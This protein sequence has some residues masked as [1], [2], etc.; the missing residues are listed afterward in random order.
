MKKVAIISMYSGL[1]DRGVETWV[2]EVSSRL[3]ELQ[4]EVLVI[5]GANLK[6]DFNKKNKAYWNLI[7]IKFSI[8]IIKKLIS[9]KPD[10]VMP[11]NGGFESL[12]IKLLSFIFKW[13]LII[14]GH[15]GIGRD[16][17]WNI[18]IRP[19]CFVS[20]SMRGEKWAKSL[21]YSKGI[22]V[23]HIPHGVDLEK[24]NPKAK[25]VKLNLARPIYLCVSSDDD[26]KRVELAK[27][28]VEKIKGSFLHIGGDFKVAPANMPSYYTACDVFTLP[29]DSY[30]AFGI[31]YLEALASGLPAVATN[32]SLRREIVGNAG[33]LVDP[34]DIDKYSKALE[35][36]ASK[37]WKDMPRNQ[38]KKFSWESVAAQY[39]K[40]FESIL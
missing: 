28:A 11:C 27:R 39:N 8:A 7:Q 2:R 1:V 4:N 17:K 18:L 9:F 40:L 20:P 6:V 31:V 14:T 13:K 19:D 23:V 35:S 32:D 16:D 37:N 34:T 21:A 38:A 29:S 33:V 12:I 24:F 25:K 22:K 10:I 3:S 36:A 30:E 15:A 5:D 26:Y